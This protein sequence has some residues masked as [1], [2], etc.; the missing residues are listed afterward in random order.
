M[1]SDLIAG[2]AAGIV[3]R[4]LWCWLVNKVRCHVQHRKAEQ[5]RALAQAEADRKREAAR[6]ERIAEAEAALAEVPFTVETRNNQE[7]LLT[8]R[9]VYLSL[10][11]MEASRFFNAGNE[12]VH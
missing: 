8:I 7:C 2:I 10:R 4:D 3:L 12:E 9:K 1:N 5:Q 6:A 11:A